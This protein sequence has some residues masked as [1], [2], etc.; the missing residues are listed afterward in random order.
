MKQFFT[1]VFLMACAFGAIAGGVCTQDAKLCEDGISYVSRVPPACNFATC[2]AKEVIAGKV[3]GISDGDT[4]TLLAADKTSVRI[5]LAEIDAPEKSQAYGQASKASLSKM[6]F[7]KQAKAVVQ[8]TDQYERKVARLFCDG[9]DANAEQV[10]RGMAWVYDKY[11]KDSSLYALQ[12]E[13][14]SAGVGLWQ[15]KNPMPPWAYRRQNR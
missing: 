1:A 6:C 11:V 7:G 3:V 10:G 15:D 5:R 14:K 12:S 13:V 8:D 2:P 9:V 4:V